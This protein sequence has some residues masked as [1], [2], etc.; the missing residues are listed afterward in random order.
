MFKSPKSKSSKARGVVLVF[1]LALFVS[2]LSAS[3]ETE[4]EEPVIIATFPLESGGIIY[5]GWT[6][7]KIGFSTPMAEADAAYLADAVK[8]RDHNYLPT[9]GAVTWEDNT[10][11]FSPAEKWKTGEKYTCS[12]NGAFSALDGRIAVIKTEMVF[13]AVSDKDVE[14]VPLPTPEIVEVVFL[15]KTEGGDYEEFFYDADEYGNNVIEGECGLRICF[16]EA[17]DFSEPFK[18][19]RMEPYRNYDVKV[20]DNWTLAVYFKAG[21]NPVKKISL[22]VQE[23]MHSLL[24]EELKRDYQFTFTEWKD[25]FAILDL[26]MLENAECLD[27]ESGIPVDQLGKERF[28]VGAEKFDDTLIIDLTWHFNDPPDLT[29]ALDALSKIKVI[30]D[31]NDDRIQKSPYLLEIGL[32]ALDYD[33]TWGDMEFGPLH[34]PYRYLIIVPGGIDGIH[35]GRGRY[36]KESIT[37]MLD[38]VDCD[39]LGL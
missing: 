27:G 22:T 15:K 3:C 12:I 28:K 38:V 33:Q 37:V 19:L 2:A 4:V 7:I 9:A 10:I 13:Y 17:M 24:G 5:G 14:A 32:Y 36:L 21:L 23:D 35:D 34:D 25:D 11:Y 31:P 16:D 30:P 26:F 29:A 18:S 1:A 39:E 8:V 20:I 6:P